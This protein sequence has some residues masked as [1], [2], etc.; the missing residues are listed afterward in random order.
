MLAKLNF[1]FWEGKAFYSIYNVYTF[2]RVIPI[3]HPT[4]T[5]MHSLSLSLSLLPTHIH[6]QCGKV[7][8]GYIYGVSFLGCVC[9]YV[10]LN[11][12]SGQGVGASCVVSV[13][14]YCLLPMVLLSCVS[15]LTSLQ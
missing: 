12:M 4:H 6:P 5:H 1:C 14:G 13:L 8:F 9:M 10:V 7:H 2:S 3:S 11:L 15:I